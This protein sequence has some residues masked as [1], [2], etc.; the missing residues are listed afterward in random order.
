MDLNH[1]ISR[2]QKTKIKELFQISGEWRDMTTAWN[3]WLWTGK[4]NIAIKD[5]IGTIGKMWLWI[6]DYLL[7]LEQC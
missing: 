3:V 4:N 7:A 6:E 5:I 2:S 1:N